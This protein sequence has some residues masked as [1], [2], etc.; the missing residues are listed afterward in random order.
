MRARDAIG[1]DAIET[2]LAD[3][4][5][6]LACLGAAFVQYELRD[7]FERVVMVLGQIFTQGFGDHDPRDFGYATSISPTAMAPRV[8]LLVTERVYALGALAVRL[9]DWLGGPD[10]RPFAT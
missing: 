4:V 6:R 8:W 9:R 5:R 2:D 1:R 7:W 10:A 3:V